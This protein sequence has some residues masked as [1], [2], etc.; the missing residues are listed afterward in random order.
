M[1]EGR[2]D[3]ERD[4]EIR[5]GERKQQSQTTDFDKLVEGLTVLCVFGVLIGGMM[6]KIQMGLES[7]EKTKAYIVIIF[8]SLYFLMHICKLFWWQGFFK[9]NNFRFKTSTMLLLAFVTVLGFNVKT[10]C[11][12]QINK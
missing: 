2:F 4:R 12:V 8:T 6:T 10:M 9:R 5:I 3:E 1:R 7:T 11:N